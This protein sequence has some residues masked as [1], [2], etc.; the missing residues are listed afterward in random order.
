MIAC[1]RYCAD[2]VP[3]VHNGSRVILADSWTANADQIVAAH[4]DLIIAAVPY[5]EK[6]VTEI[7]KSRA[8]FLGLAPKT[9]ADIYT[10]IATI[11]GAAAAADRGQQVIAATQ[12]QIERV[13]ERTAW[14]SKLRVFCEEW[15][16][17]VIPSQA[18]VRELVEAAGGD[19]DNRR[20]LKTSFDWIL[21][22]SSPHGV[23]PAIACRSKKSL[24]IADGSRRPRQRVAASSAF[25][26][27]FRTRPRRPCSR[28]WTLLPLPFVPSC[29]RAPKEF[30]RLPTFD[31]PQC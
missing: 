10:D 5:Q 28:D 2:V 11:A 24:P 16:K 25:A 12:Q 31:L 13:R 9:L 15:G 21:K 23:A 6:A 20:N 29:S 4:P 7:L 3:T 19:R 27:S 17:P 30:G 14:S 1:T 22:L 8:R 26:T 18:W